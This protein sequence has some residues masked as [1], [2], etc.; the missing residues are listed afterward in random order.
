MKILVT[1]ALLL[2]SSVTLAQ[3]LTVPALKTLLTQNRATL[4]RVNVGMSKRIVTTGSVLVEGS[5][6]QYTLTA[7]QSIVTIEGA[8]MIVFSR[9]SFAPAAS[10]AC[11]AAGFQAFSENI[12]FYDDK[13][14]LEADLAELDQAQV[15]SIVRNGNLVTLSVRGST[16]NPDGS[17]G[18]ENISIVYDLT[19]PSFKNLVST[20]A[21]DYRIA[22]TDLADQNVASFNLRNVLFCANNDGDYSDCVQ[23]DFSDI[24]FY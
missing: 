2:S 4:E 10:G 8:K 7:E 23:G 22:V 3:S 9:E 14:T 16:T 12:L 1:T 17:T 21:R 6:C 19:K 15:Q 20:T 11:Q 5:T 13:P 18:T 24:L